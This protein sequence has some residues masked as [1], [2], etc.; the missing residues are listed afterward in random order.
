[1]LKAA[2]QTAY[3]NSIDI[4][5]IYTKYGA[6]LLG[7]IQGILKHQ[8]DAEKQLIKVLSSYISNHSNLTTEKVT[9]LHLR[10]YTQQQLLA[11]EFKSLDIQPQHNGNKQDDSSLSLLTETERNIFSEIYYHGKTAAHL[12]GVLNLSENEIRSQ[13]KSSLDKIRN[14][15]GN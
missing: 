9:W 13:L 10:Q 8:P 4:R 12:S 1:M 11:F 3:E 15:H 7:Y 6:M 5:W 2:K 14:A